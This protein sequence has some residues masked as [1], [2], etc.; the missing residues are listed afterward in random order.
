MEYQKNGWVSTEDW[1]AYIKDLVDVNLGFTTGPLL[2]V[3]GE[4]A[5]STEVGITASTTQSQG[6]QPLTKTYNEI[7]VCATAD[8]V[9]TMPSAVAGKYIRIVNNG[10]E[11]LQIFPASGDNFQGEATDASITL[12]AS[13]HLVCWAEDDTIW[14]QSSGV[15]PGD[16]T[17]S[18]Q[19]NG[20]GT[21]AGSSNLKFDGTNIDMLGRIGY[22]GS[23]GGL[24]FDSSHRA[25]FTGYVG[26]GTP[27]GPST[28]LEVYSSTNLGVSFNASGQ[29][30]LNFY[31]R[32]G[33]ASAD[34]LIDVTAVGGQ[35]R[36]LPASSIELLNTVHGYDPYY[37][38]TGENTGGSAKYAIMTLEVDNDA[39]AFNVNGTDVLKLIS[40]GSLDISTY[41]I[42][43]DG[44][45]GGLSF[46]AS[47][48][49]SLTGNLSVD[50]GNM[51]W[52]GTQ[53]QLPLEEAYAVLYMDGSS[54]IATT[55]SRFWW[56]ASSESLII[57][58]ST[59]GD[60]QLNVINISERATFYVD[61]FDP[62]DYAEINLRY[63][64][65][66]TPGSSVSTT[67][68]GETVGM[69]N[70]YAVTDGAPDAFM[71]CAKIYTIQNGSSTAT[72][73]PA[74]MILET[75]QDD[76]TGNT[77]LLRLTTDGVVKTSGGRIK[78]TTRIT[79]ADSPYTALATDHFIVADTDAAITIN[80]PAGV[81]GTEY[82]IKNSGTGGYDVT[83]DGDGA[84]TIDG[85]TTQTLS[86]GEA[87]QIVFESTEEWLVI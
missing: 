5:F 31:E 35:Y 81:D 67:L 24:S 62:L 71:R 80:L 26:I 44:S 78:S 85:D 28:H 37:K 23:A 25:N 38:I 27:S 36:F 54:N 1:N 10:A 40:G 29:H 20:G 60:G 69:I 41:T 50:G 14:Q 7:S 16:P 34:L 15:T 84:E 42:G 2:T 3:K 59:G 86:D 52:T 58:N 48:N 11:N 53:L 83:V 72:G 77:D 82:Q 13:T 87:I 39:L 57:G 51:L 6:Q 47:N 32:S 74:D 73:I 56:N 49:A 66:G 61:C 70:F 21:F 4:V 17:A 9:V 68:D 76:G 19:Y 63:S 46:D 8:D 64:R 43:Y 12:G 30:V 18:I 75:T 33:V 65:G 22:D 55:A 45:A 79:S